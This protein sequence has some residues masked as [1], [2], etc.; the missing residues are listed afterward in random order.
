[1]QLRTRQWRH[2]LLGII[3]GAL[4]L[5]S[6]LGIVTH[7]V[8]LDAVLAI[9]APKGEDA[10]RRNRAISTAVAATVEAVLQGA[11]K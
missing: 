8:D 7:C 9:P 5:G 11:T 6:L 2:L 3:L 1:M 4:L 10:L